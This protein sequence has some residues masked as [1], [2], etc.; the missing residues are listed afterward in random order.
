MNPIAFKIGSFSIY[1]YGVLVAAGFLAGLWTAGRRSVHDGLDEKAVADLGV[2]I[3][4]GALLGSRLLYVITFWEDQFAGRPLGQWFNIRQGGLVFYGGFIGAAAAVILH[5][6]F[7]GKK[8]LWKIADAFA[9]SIPLGHA[10]GRLGCLMFGC[11]YGKICDPSLPWAI[12]FPAESNAFA[13]HLA[14]DH[15]AGDALLSLP[16]HPSQ[17]YSALLNFALYGFLAWFYRR[18]SFDGQVF[19]IY[20]LGYAGVRFGVEFFRGDYPAKQLALGWVTPG[21]QASVWILVIGAALLFFLARKN[22]PVV[23]QNLGQ[24]R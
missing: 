14:Q 5:T 6:R 22:R 11:C 18:K 21:Q 15:I 8:P 12:E 13:R 10:L 4:I 23:D 9:P 2:W 24:N 1:W 3:I 16:V 7:H 19:G 17:V 20:L